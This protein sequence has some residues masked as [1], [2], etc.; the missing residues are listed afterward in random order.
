M[1]MKQWRCLY[2]YTIESAEVDENVAENRLTASESL[3]HGLLDDTVVV[4]LDLQLH[5]I[6]TCRGTDEAGSDV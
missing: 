1:M 5:D 4:D 2:A 3:E 6:A